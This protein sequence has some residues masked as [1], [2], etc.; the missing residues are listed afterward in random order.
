MAKAIVDACCFIN[1][2]ASGDLRGFLTIQKWEWH[3]PHVALAEALYIRGTDENGDR[4]LIPID[5]TPYV[6]D[7]LLSVAEART[8]EETEQYVQL[9]GALDDGEAMALAIAHCRNWLLA[10]DDRKARRLAGELGVEVVT[11]P[12]LMRQWSKLGRLSRARIKL[13][14]NNIQVSA[15][16]IPGENAAEYDWWMSQ[17]A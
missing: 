10:T 1:L 11:T 3:I 14:L 7:G 6:E 2:Y 16:F 17:R 5:A 9:A 12:E 8:D 13:L 4:A 15:N